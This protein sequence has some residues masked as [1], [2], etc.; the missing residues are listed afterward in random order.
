MDSREY[1]AEDLAL[2][3]QFQ[4]WLHRPRTAAH[5][6]WPP[7]TIERASVLVRQAG[8]REDAEMNEAF[9][10]VWNNIR[11]QIEDTSERSL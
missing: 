5:A 10:H 9:L 7:A 6:S 11:M 4:Q 1:T 3:A 8:L 2:D